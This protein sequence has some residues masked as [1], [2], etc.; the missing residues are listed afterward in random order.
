M[1]PPNSCS[2]PL[3]K[4]MY[5]INGAARSARSHS[6]CLHGST[7][8]SGKQIKHGRSTVGSGNGEGAP[9]F[10]AGWAT[11]LRFLDSGGVAPGSMVCA[12]SWR[13][14]ALRFCNSTSLPY[15]G[16]RI[17]SR[18]RGRNAANPSTL[19]PDMY[20]FRL[21]ALGDLH[22]FCESLLPVRVSLPALRTSGLPC[23]RH[24]FPGQQPTGVFSLAWS[25]A[26]EFTSS[27]SVPPANKFVV[28]RE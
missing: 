25:F 17:I 1:H 13:P 12:S 23:H 20:V 10:P 16:A 28:A 18:A 15:A 22:R 8:M 7:S 5:I 26:R 14:A 21:F 4:V 24:V 19:S 9:S 3:C 11:V 27:I 6:C 2:S